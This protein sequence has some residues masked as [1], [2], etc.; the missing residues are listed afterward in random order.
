MENWT[1]IW[2][3]LEKFTSEVVNQLRNNIPG[4]YRLSYKHQDGNYYVFYIGQSGDSQGIKERLSQHFLESEPNVCISNYLKKE[5]CYFRY[6]HITNKEV[7][8]A[9][10]RQVYNIYQ[11]TCN[12]IQPNGRDDIQVNLS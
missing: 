5:K 3:K 11:P 10:E 1:L 8:N 9:T 6:A 7:R 4:V 2:T 12:E